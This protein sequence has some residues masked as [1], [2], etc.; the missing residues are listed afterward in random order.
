ML[1]RRDIEAVESS[2]R[3]RERGRPIIKVR[4]V[5]SLENSDAANGDDVLWS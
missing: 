4:R 1:N 5:D 2:F 3:H